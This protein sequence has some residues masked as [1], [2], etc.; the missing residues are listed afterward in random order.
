MVEVGQRDDHVDSVLAH[1]LGQGRDVLGLGEARDERVAAGTV[2]SRREDARVGG[3]RDG[4][5]LVEGVDHVDALAGAGEKD[6]CHNGERVPV[7][8]KRREAKIRACSVCSSG[9]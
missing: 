8:A 3:E 5:R 7:H 6:D 2:E 9:C 4:A 1:Q